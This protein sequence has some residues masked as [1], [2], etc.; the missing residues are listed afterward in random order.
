[1]RPRPEPRE[2]D[3]KCMC[4]KCFGVPDDDEWA[5]DLI[6]EQEEMEAGS[7]PWLPLRTMRHH[8]RM[9]LDDGE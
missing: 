6:W 2:H 1:M 3:S 5:Y 4:Y 7:N 9:D 8:H